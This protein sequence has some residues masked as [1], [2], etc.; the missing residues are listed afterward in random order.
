[1]RRVV[2]AIGVDVELVA[3]TGPVA[4][5]AR[6]NL[7]SFTDAVAAFAGND[8]EAS[9]QSLLAYLQA[10]DDYAQG[11]PVASPTESDSVKLMTVHKAKGLEWDVVFVP[12]LTESVF[13]SALS[14]PRWPT[15]AEALP[16]PLRGDARTLPGML[17]WTTKADRTFRARSVEHEGH[18]E[19]R[20][21]Y[22]A[23]TRARRELIV[24]GCW[25]GPTQKRPRGPSDYLTHLRGLL[26]REARRAAPRTAERGDAV[27]LDPWAAEP[28]VEVNPSRA[29]AQT[30]VWPAPLDPGALRRRTE[31]ARLLEEARLRYAETGSYDLDEDLLLDQAA[32]VAEWDATVDRLI[33]E[34]RQSH[35]RDHTVELPPTLSATALMRLSS[36]PRGL[37]RDLVRPM[38]RRPSAAARFGTRFHAWVESN[39]RQQQL[40]DPTDIPGAADEGIGDDEEL[41]EL[42]RA[43]AEGP[44]G[45][46][47]PHQVEAPFALVLAR[48]VVR[49]RIDAVYAEGEGFRVVDWKTNQE[50]TADP[51]QLAVYRLAWAELAGVPVGSVA[52]SFY[53]VRS[54]DLVTPDDLP[55]RAELESLLDL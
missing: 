24:S 36:D 6:D 21:G 19:R 25:W 11:L 49:G 17:E 55:D 50:Q 39:A 30:A 22:V 54:G 44:F 34:A 42:C 12:E 20:L 32:V 13:P 1:V 31:A 33:E 47:V 8:S 27:T 16:A 38:P 51:L 28:E 2:D 14:R 5:Q 4:G 52:A 7:A 3:A 48:Q 23:F 45:N 10:E 15:S 53:Y 26:E 29:E 41:R 9:L 43:F 18:E 40:L 37:A 46:R 35:V